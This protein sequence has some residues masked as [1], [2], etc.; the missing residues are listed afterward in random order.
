MPKAEP[1]LT[2]LAER[3]NV[4]IRTLRNW[5]KR[6]GFP[7]GASAEEVKAWADRNNLGRLKD[8]TLTELKADLMREQIALARAKNQREAGEVIDREVV[9]DMLGVLAQKLDLLLRLKLEVELGPRVAG[10]SAAEA[11]VEGAAILEEIR[12]VVSKNIA[13]FESEALK[14]QRV[15]SE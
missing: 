8:A 11:N 9:E 15:A 3:L 7:H 14:T 6:D 4:D 13:A 5:R 12:E 1:E 2:A 10:K